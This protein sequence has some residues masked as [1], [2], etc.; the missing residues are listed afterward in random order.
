MMKIGD[1]VTQCSAGYWQIIDI[2]P[3]YALDGD[4]DANGKKY[5]KGQVIGQWVVLKKA[6]TPKMKP[7]IDFEYI[8]PYW[9]KPVGSEILNKIET[10][11]LENPAFKEKFDNAAVK[12][13]PAITNCWI[14]FPEEEEEQIKEAMNSLPEKYT[15]DEFWKKFKKYKKYISKPPTKYLINF[16]AY[17]WDMDKKGNVVYTGCTLEKL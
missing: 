16:L 6:F 8:D 11:F 1:F 14:N 7:K 10:Y 5:K 4:T 13:S 12:L 9:M 2:K 3:K 17:P 15:M